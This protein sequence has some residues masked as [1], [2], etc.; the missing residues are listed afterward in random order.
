MLLYLI[1]TYLQIKLMYKA[2][3]P[4]KIHLVSFM[5]FLLLA[6]P[7]VA[8]PSLPEF[9]SFSLYFTLPPEME[10]QFEY[11]DIDVK[12]L[13]IDCQYYYNAVT[14]KAYQEFRTVFFHRAT[15]EAPAQIR[16]QDGFEL[17]GGNLEFDSIAVSFQWN[18]KKYATTV[19]PAADNVRYGCI[20]DFKNEYKRLAPNICKT[21]T[22]YATGRP[23]SNA[24]KLIIDQNKVKPKLKLRKPL[25]S[26]QLLKIVNSDLKLLYPLVIA[27]GDTC[28]IAEGQGIDT[29][30]L[31]FLWENQKIQ[32]KIFHPDYPSLLLDSVSRHGQGGLRDYVYLL[33]ENES[34]FLDGGIRLP[35][36]N[37]Y[38]ELAFW[39]DPSTSDSA[40]D[41]IVQ[42]L[43]TRHKLK[44][45]KDW[46]KLIQQERDSL[47]SEYVESKYGSFD[48]QLEHI[49]HFRLEQETDF[50]YTHI[51]K[52]AEEI[53]DV[54]IPLSFYQYLVPILKVQFKSGLSEEEVD[55][56]EK[57]YL[58]NFRRTNYNSV[59]T[60]MNLIQ[61]TY[62][63]PNWLFIP[64]YFQEVIMRDPR[65]RYC[66][67]TEYEYILTD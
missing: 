28:K 43:I 63:F 21:Q 16:V 30:V 42:R 26:A 31:P 62:Q 55:K 58:P 8:Q 46:K 29:I 36:K 12:D 41:K 48:D 66:G 7:T 14:Y 22:L 23:E 60:E 44:L 59:Q 35:L 64:N 67:G 47:G 56:F 27:N 19:L 18:G 38:K 54:S 61:R 32:L 57:E 40:L 13:N 33:R 51:P 52:Y 15:L 6:S 10:A 50:S 17:F 49:L 1:V 11:G 34:Y 5:V 9:Y 53:N 37:G 24:L 2:S 20:C 4:L 39:F 45:T 3:T 25:P 65:V